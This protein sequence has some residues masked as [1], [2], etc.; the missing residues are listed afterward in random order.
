MAALG[1]QL[2]QRWAGNI[3]HDQEVLAILFDKIVNSDSVGMG[4]CG[5]SPRL[6]SKA[7]NSSQVILIQRAQDFDGYQPFHAMIPCPEDTCHT[8]SS[9]MFAYLIASGN[10]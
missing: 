9:N 1:D 7:L 4:K 5:G 2:F 3:L 6:A 10:Q 8:T